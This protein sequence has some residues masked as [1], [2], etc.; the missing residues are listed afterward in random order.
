M[1]KLIIIVLL[2]AS[3]TSF[4][5]R[6]VSRVYSLPIETDLNNNYSLLLDSPYFT[7]GLKR[8]DLLGLKNFLFNGLSSFETDPIFVASA[9]HG[10]TATNITNWNTAYGW[11]NHALG[12]YAQADQTMYIG[13]TEV[14]I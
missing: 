13:T 11:G 6:A 10:I 7:T 4:G 5:Q 9:A 14:A 8:I 12:G 2:L 3:A 1:K